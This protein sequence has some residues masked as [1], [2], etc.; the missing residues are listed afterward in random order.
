MRAPESRQA[1]DGETDG[2]DR[3]E[4]TSES[5]AGESSGSFDDRLIRRILQSL[6]LRSFRVQPNESNSVQ[7]KGTL[8]ADADLTGTRTL[9]ED[10]TK[11]RIGRTVGLPET[12]EGRQPFDCRP[13]FYSESLAGQMLSNGVSISHATADLLIRLL[14][15]HTIGR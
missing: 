10:P 12:N 2:A 3:R 13:S 9:F 14:F 8:R 11:S 7:S 4:Q 6:P 5:E 15:L 1:D